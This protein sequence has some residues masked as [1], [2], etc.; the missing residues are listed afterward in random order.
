MNLHLAT[1]PPRWGT[2][3]DLRWRCLDYFG[4]CCCAE[5]RGSLCSTSM[6]LRREGR[7]VSRDCQ[8][9]SFFFSRTS[10]SLC[11][12]KIFDAGCAVLLAGVK[13][14]IQVPG[15]LR[16]VLRSEEELC[17]AII[18]FAS[19]RDHLRSFR[20]LTT[21]NHFVALDPPS[22]PGVARDC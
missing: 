14:K 16:R 7:R 17:G 22:R 12:A 11:S 21:L 20:S 5:G 3:V 18:A 1:L 6:G 15:L 2:T 8:H 13:K 9:F 4:H 10:G 19:R